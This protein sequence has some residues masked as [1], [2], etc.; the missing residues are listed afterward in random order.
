MQRAAAE[1][2]AVEVFAMPE[3]LEVV[4]HY[5]PTRDLHSTFGGTCSAFATGAER[6]LRRRRH[7]DNEL[8]F[9][10]AWS[11]ECAELVKPS[12][13]VA[14]EAFQPLLQETVSA[15]GG[16]VL[17]RM[18]ELLCHFRTL[19]HIWE[20]THLQVR[21]VNLQAQMAIDAATLGQAK[22]GRVLFERE[23]RL[24]GK[25]MG[26]PVRWGGWAWGAAAGRAAGLLGARRAGN[27]LSFATAI[28]AVTQSRPLADMQRLE[29]NCMR[30]LATKAAL[31]RHCEKELKEREEEEL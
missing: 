25:R 13:E 27:V 30:Q 12:A 7:S 21:I 14:T 24:L 18:L 23:Q 15:G 3:L 10:R 6:A 1:G 19:W 31:V 16:E 29:V 11:A 22:L 26:L 17:R 5:L 4:M 28:A 8:G 9:I 2:A 20:T